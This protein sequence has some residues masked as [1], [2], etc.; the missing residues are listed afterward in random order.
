M[1]LTAACPACD[2]DIRV[3]G[4]GSLRRHEAD[5]QRCTGADAVMVT[6]GLPWA[7]PPL[8]QNAV[9]RMHH[10][11]E[12]KAK[13]HLLHELRWVIR[14]AKPHP[15]IEPC[16]FTLHYRP[17]TRRLCDADGLAV[18]GKVVLDALVHEGVLQADDW[19]HVRETRQRIH[20]PL[21]GMPGTLWLTVS[22]DREASA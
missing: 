14:A 20:P 4:D 16:V 3:N 8:T 22:I 17:G 12:A 2:Q 21:A 13:A 19:R 6:I 1:S 5:G 11:V 15:V 7:A 18:T 10:H 9:R